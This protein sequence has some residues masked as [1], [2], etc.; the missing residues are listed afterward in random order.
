M[1]IPEP[2][3]T[4]RP[5]A[6]RSRHLLLA[7]AILVGVVL[8]FYLTVP[9]IG[10]LTASIT[11]AIL[12]APLH[13]RIEAMLGRPTLAALIS[14]LAVLLIVAVPASLVA[15]RLIAEAATSAVVIQRKVAAGAVQDIMNAHPALAPIGEWIAQQVDLPALLSGLASW[16]SSIG[17]S[18]VRGSMVQLA[19]FALT[20]YLLFYF[21]RDRVAARRAMIDLSPLEAGE[22]ERLFARFIDTVQ[23]IVYGTV[24]V[25]AIQGTLGGLMFW[26]LGLPGPLLWGVVMT[27]LSVV[28]V[29]G[30]FVVWI[31]ASILLALNGNWSDAIILALWGALVVGNIDNILRPMLVGNR[32]RLHTVPAFIAMLG[33]L[34][35]LGAPGF[36]L[37]PLVVTMTLLLIDIWR[38][39]AGRL[40]ASGAPEMPP[41]EI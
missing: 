28:P 29:L 36:I 12:F 40:R 14:V 15:G 27:I 31:P 5:M 18:F 39:R 2:A 34:L 25:A 13:S 41:R 8:C 16:L 21:L 26:F 33:G 6:L 22:T 19:A 4:E 35:V 24:A 9:F 10:P 30:S 38:G 1:A 37:G 7:S 20:F 23:A 32:L 3:A 11:L 17:T